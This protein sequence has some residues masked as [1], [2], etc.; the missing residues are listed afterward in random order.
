MG[1]LFDL[2]FLLL[3]GC[4]VWLFFKKQNNKNQVLALPGAGTGAS[5]LFFQGNL[6]PTGFLGQEF[7]ILEFK[8]IKICSGA[9]ICLPLAGSPVEVT[10]GPRP[11]EETEDLA[12]ELAMHIGSP[13]PQK[14]PRDPKTRSGGLWLC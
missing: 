1:V 5:R 6:C 14:L 12:G 4:F 3:F 8:R 2:I 10:G 11:R 9:G 13:A 7:K